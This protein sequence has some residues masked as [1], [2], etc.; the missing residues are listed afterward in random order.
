MRT[1]VYSSDVTD[2]EWKILESLLPTVNYSRGG[3]PC[4]YEKRDIVNAIMYVTR[5]GCAWRMLP[6]D[7]PPFPIVFHYFTLWKQD[8]TWKRIHD[9]L[10]VKVRRAAGRK[11][12][13]S[14]GILDSQT[15]KTSDQAGSRGYDA[16]K[17]IKGRKRHILVD[18]LG[19]IILMV[20]HAANVQD[21]DGAKLVL[22]AC[23]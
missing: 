13:P 11:A 14:A 12:A 6:K 8:G 20:V 15:V 7:F 16:G 3:A 22:R 4:T 19:L 21:R 2:E 1:E 17:K 5:S 10:V 23:R 18:T 9:A